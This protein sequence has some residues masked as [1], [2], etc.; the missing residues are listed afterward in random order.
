VHVYEE[1]KDVLHSLLKK[2]K[3]NNYKLLKELLSQFPINSELTSAG[4]F[5]DMKNLSIYLK[6]QHLPV[7]IC[8]ACPLVKKYSHFY[9]GISFLRI[10]Q[11]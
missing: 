4:S 5:T 6:M 7:Q 3:E 9:L 10:L 2:K 1:N 8:K 11:K